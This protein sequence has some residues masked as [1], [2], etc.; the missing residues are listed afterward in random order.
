MQ[1]SSCF[2]AAA[3]SV[4]FSVDSASDCGVKPGGRG[5]GVDSLDW[6]LPVLIQGQTQ[7]SQKGAVGTGEEEERRREPVVLDRSQRCIIL[8]GLTVVCLHELGPVWERVSEP[9]HTVECNQQGVG[10][11]FR[12]LIL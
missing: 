9:P 11:D 4:F 6:L 8:S 1:T 5:A 7:I 3:L 12:S 2:R 10:E